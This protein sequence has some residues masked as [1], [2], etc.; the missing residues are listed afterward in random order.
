MNRIGD[1]AFLLG[2]FLLFASLPSRTLELA[3]LNR[4][5]AGGMNAAQLTTAA[6]V[7]AAQETTSSGVFAQGPSRRPS[8]GHGLDR[9]R[10]RASLSVGK[11]RRLTRS[12]PREL[13][14][15]G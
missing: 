11:K 4:A 12:S 9:R 10:V 15:P 3:D 2:M 13:G 5:A 8:L 14:E 6:S 1:F 7:V